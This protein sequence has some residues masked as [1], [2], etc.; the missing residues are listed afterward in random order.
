MNRAQ[1]E[2]NSVYQTT[3]GQ[4]WHFLGLQERPHPPRPPTA[5]SCSQGWKG[6]ERRNHSHTQGREHKEGTRVPSAAAAP[7][8]AA[9]APPPSPP[10]DHLPPESLCCPC[11]L[12]PSQLRPD[13]CPHWRCPHAALTTFPPSQGSIPLGSETGL[14]LQAYC[15]LAPF[16][17]QVTLDI[18]QGSQRTLPATHRK[19]MGA[20]EPGHRSRTRRHPQ[21]TPTS[22]VTCDSTF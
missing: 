7:G 11:P 21:F 6:R 22:R 18:S 12:L 17:R 1:F 15:N 4:A 8:P 13:T 20:S 5:S 9:C 2:L 16:L 19:S 3:R 14:I 10:D